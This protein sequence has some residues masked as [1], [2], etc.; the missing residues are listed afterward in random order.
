M[1]Q[2]LKFSPA[3]TEQ[4]LSVLGTFKG[5]LAPT[6]L[7][8]VSCRVTRNGL[9]PSPCSLSCLRA[10]RGCEG[11]SWPVEKNWGFSQ[12]GPTCCLDHR[13]IWPT[14]LLPEETRNSC[15]SCKCNQ[16]CWKL[17]PVPLQPLHHESNGFRLAWE[18]L[19]ITA[20]PK[21]QVAGLPGWRKGPRVSW[22]GKKVVVRTWNCSE[23]QTWGSY[24]LSYQALKL[25]AS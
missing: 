20:S 19:G 18:H 24:L 13:Q 5:S 16:G 9:Q 3:G 15:L 7:K 25:L 14:A 22:W 11:F 21:W 17:P 2:V 4:L 23:I 8:H 1:K 10:G 6:L 12:H